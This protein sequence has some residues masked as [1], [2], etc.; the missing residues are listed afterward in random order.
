MWQKAGAVRRDPE[1]AVRREGEARQEA[2]T[3]S[4][5]HLEQAVR[6]D[7]EQAREGEATQEAG[8]G[9]GGHLEQAVRRDLEQSAWEERMRNFEEMLIEQHEEGVAQFEKIQTMMAKFPTGSHATIEE[10]IEALTD[11][12]AGILEL[13]AQAYA[14]LE[15]MEGAQAEAR[16]DLMDATVD[17]INETRFLKHYSYLGA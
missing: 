5:G 14:K 9:S 6:R 4:G 8:T 7:L 12:F 13:S 15:A 3:G 17:G 16:T 2:G 11:Q 1:Q 10:K